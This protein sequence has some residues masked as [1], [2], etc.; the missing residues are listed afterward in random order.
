MK[1]SCLFLI[2][3][4]TIPSHAGVNLKNG[5][6]YTSYTDIALSGGIQ[7]LKITRTCNSKSIEVGWFGR[8]W[9]SNFET[10]LNVSADGSIVINENGSGSQTRFT[11]KGQTD[12]R[13]AAKKIVQA[14]AKKGNLGGKTA[15]ELEDKLTKNAELRHSY[16]KLFEI[17]APVQVGKKFRSQGKG[18]Q[19]LVKLRDG[20]F[21]RT[22]VSGKMEY[23]NKHGILYKIRHKNLSNYTV[24]LNPKKRSK[25]SDLE[26]IVD[27]LG[28]RLSFE[29][30]SSGR[31]KRIYSSNKV[32]AA[33]KYKDGKYLVES[34]DSERSA[35]APKG[36]KYKYEYDGHYISGIKYADG[37]KKE[38]KYNVS[39]GLVTSVKEKDGTKREYNFRFD[40]KNPN[41]HYWTEVTTTRPGR[42]PRK[43]SYEYELRVR[44]DGQQYNYR[45]VTDVNGRKTE[46]VYDEKSGLPIKITR[47]GRVTSFERNADGMV[48]KKTTPDG[49]QVSL[50]YS[51]SCKKVSQVDRRSGWVKFS[52]NKRCD[53]VRIQDSKGKSLLLSYD[54]DRQISKMIERDKKTKQSIELTFVYNASGRPVEIKMGKQGKVRVKYDRNG[55]IAKVDSKQGQKMAI[56]ISRTFQRLLSMV[57]SAK[58]SV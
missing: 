2:L 6:F 5:N 20:G 23:F 32:E 38:I 58:I 56:K 1:K 7:T 19:E 36:N 51:R 34:I 14:M 10:N 26:S 54:R 42:K 33:Y 11:A 18:H 30:L 4:L 45:I 41:L 37:S 21:L 44:P 29:W 46:R 50:R 35:K 55:G 17:K 16:A 22:S 28:R 53:L 27:S 12:A 15:S 25:A 31:V 24:T 40:P 52:Y 47:G 9:G 3:A 39:K 43:D 57:S 8:C 49:K 48:T 13:G